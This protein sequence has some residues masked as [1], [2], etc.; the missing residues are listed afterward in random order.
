MMMKLK[1]GGTLAK[2]FAKKLEEKFFRADSIGL[3]VEDL[4]KKLGVSKGTIFTKKSQ[5]SEVFKK[6]KNILTLNKKVKPL[7]L[8][9]F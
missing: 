6:I 1:M 5:D 2:A 4:A 3:S 8:G 9:M 7:Q